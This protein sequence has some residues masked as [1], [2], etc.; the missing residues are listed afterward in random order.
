MPGLKG[1]VYVRVSSDTQT[2]GTSLEGQKEACLQY[3]ERKGINIAKVFI[4]KG[5]S[6]TAANRTELIKALDYCKENKGISAFVV[7]KIDR[8]ARN[9]TD[10]Y[11][12]QAQLIKY[13]TKLHSVTEPMISEGPIGKMTEAVLAG[14]AQFEN[15]IRKQ[16]CEGGMQR[17]IMEG[18]WPWKPPIGYTH[19]KTRTNRRKTKPDDPDEARFYLIQRG[20]KEF[21]TGK[22]SI[23]SLT[24]VFNKWGLRTNNGKKLYVQMVER[25]L[26]DKFYAGILYNPWTKEEYPGQ[27]R[28][29]ITIEEYYQIQGIKSGLSNKA[30]MP[31]LIANPDFPLRK[32][33]RCECGKELTGAW[34]SGRGKKYAYYNCNNKE[35]DEYL[36]YIKNRE[37]EDKFISLL[38]D[39]T[40]GKEFLALIRKA[41]LKE[42]GNRTKNTVTEFKSRDSKIKALES[43]KERLIEMRLNDAISSEEFV[44]MKNDVDGQIA[45]FKSSK[46]IKK[47]DGFN[48]EKATDFAIDYMS[49]LS[50]RWQ[51]IKDAKQKQRFQ[52]WVLPD[53]IKY[54][55]MNES[56]GTAEFC[57]TI[58]LSKAFDGNESYFVAG[59][60]FEPTTF[61]F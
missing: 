39:V 15:D 48:L 7:W 14:Y 56:F 44:K 23:T 57:Y 36:S 43:R 49:N 32:F 24:E 46:D 26:K 29:M 25:L 5:E 58:K 27:H 42:W 19:S 9:M 12:L 2:T 61:R 21:T 45:E 38:A 8:F 11:G 35:C 52:K 18:I 1:I 30:V 10:H 41:I 31:R 20:L 16:R 22:H 28:P 6:A 33:A 51:E 17:K 60:G 53:G 59:V 3:A 4:E 55:R 50:Q 47:T 54:H 37:I 34:H 40:P 13:G